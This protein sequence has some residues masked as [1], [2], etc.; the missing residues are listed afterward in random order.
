MSRRRALQDPKEN[1]NRPPE[2]RRR[3]LLPMDRG[4]FVLFVGRHSKSLKFI[5]ITSLLARAKSRFVKFDEI[6]VLVA[7]AW[8]TSA[9]HTCPGLE[10]YARRRTS[11]PQTP[12]EY[13][14]SL[15]FRYDCAS[16]SRRVPKID[17]LLGRPDLPYFFNETREFAKLFVNMCIPRLAF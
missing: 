4:L 2:A 14:G 8:A 17:F 15:R 10:E 7:R 12:T 3:L 9:K 13:E 1:R 6:D 11:K 16:R 5:K